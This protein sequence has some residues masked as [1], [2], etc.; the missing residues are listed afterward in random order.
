MYFIAALGVAIMLGFIM[1][2]LTFTVVYLL[3]ESFRGAWYVFLTNVICSA[4]AMFLITRNWGG[5]ECE[6]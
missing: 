5:D 4:F 1:L 2:P 3:L 6:E